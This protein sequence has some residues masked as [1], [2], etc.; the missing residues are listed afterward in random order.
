VSG[1]QRWSFFRQLGMTSL[2]VY[3]VHIEL[4]YGRW[5]G[6]WKEAMTVGQVMVFTAVLLA[7]LTALSIFQTRG[8]FFGTF[9]KAPPTPAARRASGD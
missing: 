1:V 3:W 5:F 6:I 7:L 4:V 8:M 9:F 2:L